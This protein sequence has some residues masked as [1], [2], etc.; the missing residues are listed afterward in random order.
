MTIDLTTRV[1]KVKVEGVIGNSPGPNKSIEE[2]HKVGRSPAGMI[3]FGSM[4]AE[5]NIGNIGTTYW[6]DAVPDI[7]LNS[8]GLPCRPP[9]TYL[10]RLVELEQYSKPLVVSFAGFSVADFESLAQ[11]LDPENL[12]T[13]ELNLT[14]PNIAGKVIFAYDFDLVQK[15]IQEVRSILGVEANILVKLNYHPDQRYIQEMAVLLAEVGIDAVALCNTVPYG[16]VL[17]PKT[18]KPVITPNKG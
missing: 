5:E 3:M 4:T 14:C 15:T 17:D 7:A 18:L 13:V 1:G 12:P 11:K 8:L 16:L 9:E 6:G 10:S 2:C